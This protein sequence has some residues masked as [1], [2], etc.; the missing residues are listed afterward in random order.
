MLFHA[1]KNAPLNARQ[2][3]K[4]ENDQIEVPLEAPGGL[5]S[6]LELG[7]LPEKEIK[8]VEAALVGLEASEGA[9]ELQGE[10]ILSVLPASS[11][12][13]L[14]EGGS[15]VEGFSPVSLENLLVSYSPDESDQVR[16]L[17]SNQLE[18]RQG[19]CE[20]TAGCHAPEVIGKVF[21]G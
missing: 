10:S 6:P 13:K 9:G 2:E 18:G 16:V 12:Q 1:G 7:V 4:F 21:S 15:M 14:M 20:L 17:L 8:V 3:F 19:L 5:G 11:P